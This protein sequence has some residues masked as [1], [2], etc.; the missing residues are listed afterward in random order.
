MNALK[1][2]A[3][4]VNKLSDDI[5]MEVSLCGD[6][7]GEITAITPQGKRLLSLTF[8]QGINDGCVYDISKI[9]KE[10]YLA[11]EMKRNV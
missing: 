5:Q 8:Q 9:N 4:M 2:F 11:Y 6:G 1:V 7:S 10:G 3:Q